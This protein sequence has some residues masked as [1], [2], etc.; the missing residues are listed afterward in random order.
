MAEVMSLLL[1]AGVHGLRR[2]GPWDNA[3]A[4]WNE[5]RRPLPTLWITF[6]DESLSPGPGPDGNHVLNITLPN[7]GVIS[8]KR[9]TLS[10]VRTAGHGMTREELSTALPGGWRCPPDVA[11]RLVSGA[12]SRTCSRRRDRENRWGATRVVRRLIS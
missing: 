11:V 6:A 2:V 7:S 1:R 3:A 4:G 8:F 5:R 12:V 10:A 9:I